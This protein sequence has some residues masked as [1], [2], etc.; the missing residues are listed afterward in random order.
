MFPYFLT[1]NQDY[2]NEALYRPIFELLV[3]KFTAKEDF[4]TLSKLSLEIGISIIKKRAAEHAEKLL[5]VLE[6]FIN[7]AAGVSNL[8]FLGVL[9]PFLS[10]N[11][12]LQL[13]EK[14]ITE[15]FK[16]NKEAEQRAI[17][18]CMPD[19]M[20][21]F[22]QPTQIVESIY[23]NISTMTEE[24]QVGQ[25]YLFSGLLKGIGYRETQ[26]YLDKILAP[27]YVAKTRAEKLGRIHLLNALVQNFGR[28]V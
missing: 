3:L 5:L 26:S 22:K 24:L 2:I 10:G 17:S 4:G 23:Q 13:V 11:K 1:I 14:R 19:L 18:K 28:V 12:N 9:A 6:S 27:T 25:A 16:S 15:L 20:S 21:F 7:R 8:I